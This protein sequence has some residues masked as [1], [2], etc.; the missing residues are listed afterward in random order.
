[1]Y[2]Y[3]FNSTA[4]WQ[5]AAF[6]TMQ[7]SM[8]AA[9]VIQIRMMQMSL[10]VMKPEEATRMLLEKP[11]TF[12]RATELSARA[13]AANKGLASAVIAGLNPIAR[14]TRTNAARLSKNNG[15]SGTTRKGR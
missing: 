3:L 15:L 8:A 11:Q 7:M 6:S 2:S 13:L 5:R 14:A 1:M 9:T 4:Q 12:M 10:G